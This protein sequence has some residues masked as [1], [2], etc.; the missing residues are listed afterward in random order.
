MGP[1]FLIICWIFGHRQP[2]RVVCGVHLKIGRVKIYVIA[3]TKSCLPLLIVSCLINFQSILG[4]HLIAS[5]LI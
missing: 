4:K 2:R 5:L 3:R 1:P